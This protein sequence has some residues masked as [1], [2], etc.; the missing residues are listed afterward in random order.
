LI[1]GAEALKHRQKS[2]TIA[3]GMPEYIELKE[4]ILVDFKEF[5]GNAED[6]EDS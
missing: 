4:S 1:S 2:R 3:F 5:V 6:N